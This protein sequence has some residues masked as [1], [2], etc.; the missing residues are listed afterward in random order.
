M[1][2]FFP[3]FSKKTMKKLFLIAFTATVLFSCADAGNDR[4]DINDE[5]TIMNSP[6]TGTVP[7][8]ETIPDT[9][10]IKSD[11]VIVAD[12]SNNNR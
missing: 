6:G 3:E 4:D 5:D 10:T 12:S 7:P 9:M 8:S 2:G 11:S 1:A